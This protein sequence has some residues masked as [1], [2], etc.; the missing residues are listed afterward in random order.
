[1]A[2]E[3]FDLALQLHG[4]GR[5]S[6]P[7]VRRLRAALTVGLRAPDAEPLDRTVPY[8]YFQPEIM[9]YLEVVALAGARPVTVE[10]RIVVTPADR[11]AAAVRASPQP[12][13]AVI[14]PG[15]T[16]PRRRWPTDRFA[17]IADLLADQ[18][19]SVLV[20][21][22]PGERELVDAVLAGMQRPGRSLCG[23]LDLP[24]LVGLLEGAEIVV[25][26]DTGPVHLSAAVGTPSVGVY[27]I[28]NLV[29][30]VPP[31]RTVHRPVP[32]FRATCPVCGTDCTAADC[33]HRVSFVADVP[34]EAVAAEVHALTTSPPL[35]CST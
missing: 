31:F 3:R 14:H 2:G 18:G 11:A 1:M 17:A 9:R 8:V 28:G 21:G 29:N 4:G 13:Y 23:V 20:T 7:F 12:P 30:G 19:L 34:V 26:N 22:T 5:Y 6:N 25:S 10:P 16:D 35:G 27:W 24:G 32:S 33:S 15:A